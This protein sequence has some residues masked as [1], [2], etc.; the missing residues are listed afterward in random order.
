MTQPQMELILPRGLMAESLIFY[1]LQKFEYRLILK[2]Y[3]LEVDL[4]KFQGLAMHKK[5]K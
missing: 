1:F 3:N 5:Y 4:Y 2:Y